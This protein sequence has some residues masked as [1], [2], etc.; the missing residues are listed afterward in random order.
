MMNY[1]D[2]I[3]YVKNNILNSLPDVYREFEVSVNKTLKNNG[4]ELDGL[5]IRG[6]DNIAPVIYLNGYYEKYNDGYSLENIMSEISE[7]YK[8]NAEHKAIPGNLADSLRDFDAIKENVFSK[9]VNTE[10]NKE[11]LE[12][13]PHT[14][15]EDLSITYHIMIS[16]D[17]SGIASA[18][19]TNLM[20]AEY[21]VTAEELDRIAKENMSRNNP[22]VFQSMYEIMKE[23]LAPDVMRQDMD[24][25]MADALFDDMFPSG[26]DPMYVLSNESKVNGAIWMTSEE[27]LDSISEKIGGDFFLLPSSI[28]ECIIV[29]KEGFDERELRNMVMEVNS[30]QVSREERLSDNVYSYDS[31]EHKLTLATDNQTHEESHEH[32]LELEQNKKHSSVK[33]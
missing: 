32:D 11:L 16:R 6:H 18:P 7:T 25:D 12:G 8:M 15:F 9:I 2:F 28:H 1:D 3:E 23:M 13:R 26:G 17:P 33:H 14:E 5:M 10:N 30:T 27:A 4:L 21:G 22:M 24:K 20:A 29:P 31:K 19:I